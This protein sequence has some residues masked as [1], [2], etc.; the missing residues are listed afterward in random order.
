VCI[1]QRSWAVQKNP[2]GMA[3]G[4]KRVE[5]EQQDKLMPR[6]RNDAQRLMTLLCTKKRLRWCGR[7]THRAGAGDH[8]RATTSQIDDRRRDAPVTCWA[9]PRAGIDWLIIGMIVTMVAV[10]AFCLITGAG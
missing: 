2:G 1:E 9:I 4:E 6:S 10:T 3:T 8:D 7:L 5:C